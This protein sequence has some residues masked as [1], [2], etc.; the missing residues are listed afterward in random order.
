MNRQAKPPIFQ[1]QAR[2]PRIE[3]GSEGRPSEPA[4]GAVHVKRQLR[5]ERARRHPSQRVRLAICRPTALP[6]GSAEER[7]SPSE[8]SLLGHCA[9]EA[10]GSEP[11]PTPRL[12][13]VQR[14]G[15]EGS[16]WGWSRLAHHALEP[17]QRSG[18][19]GPRPPRPADG[20]EPEGIPSPGR[21]LALPGHDGEFCQKALSKRAIGKRGVASAGWRRSRR[22]ALKCPM[23]FNTLATRWSQ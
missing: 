15:P 20:V 1:T 23:H 14:R 11:R 16:P 22:P 4:A 13:R 21:G 8:A 12:S 17:R 10:S 6:P 2:F 3:P 19:N 18:V 9:V 7:L 5:R